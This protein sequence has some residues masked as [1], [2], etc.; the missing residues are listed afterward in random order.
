M[1][2]PLYLPPRSWSKA[3]DKISASVHTR[4][5]FKSLQSH[6]LGLSTC[7]CAPPLLKRPDSLH[8]HTLSS[9]QSGGAR[10]SLVKLSGI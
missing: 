6:L 7:F 9:S 1:P 10:N 2:Q 3:G 5:L 8:R 4:L